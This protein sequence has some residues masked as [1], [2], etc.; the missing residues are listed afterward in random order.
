MLQVFEHRLERRYLDKFLIPLYKKEKDLQSIEKSLHKKCEVNAVSSSTRDKGRISP[1]SQEF[2]QISSP[3]LLSE[4]KGISNVN[5]ELVS[6]DSD[7]KSIIYEDV[8]TRIRVE[9]N[10]ASR[11]QEGDARNTE[12]FEEEEFSD[13][14]LL[15]SGTDFRMVDIFRY[16][17]PDRKEAFTCWNT[18]TNA[19]STNYGTRIDYLLCNEEFL[20]CI[21]DSL[22]L[23]DVMGSDH[24]PVAVLIK[25][26]LISSGKFPCIC[27]KF[28]PE[29]RGQQQKLSSYF[30]P[31]SSL[32]D[33]QTKTNKNISPV[34]K[35]GSLIVQS[36][37]ST[38]KRKSSN[39]KIKS[40]NKK[41]HI[42]KQMKLSSFF[43]SKVSN[44]KNQTVS[45]NVE[46]NRCE[47]QSPE[48]NLNEMENSQ[49]APSHVN[50]SDHISVELNEGSS[51]C[52]SNDLPKTA[53]SR[54]SCSESGLKS[55]SQA[56]K[57][58]WGF[59]MKGPEPPP[60]C[61]GHKE[62]AVLLTVKKKGPNI[63]RQFYA[64]ARGVGKEGDP[65]ARCNFFKWVGK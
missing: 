24:C 56:K 36:L 16:F 62:P 46:V 50:E 47:N 23:Q 34:V 7:E 22:I 14:H 11:K 1:Q 38:A 37:Q 4:K 64:C 57:S 5:Q 29:F 30:Q 2:S 32:P 59:L 33:S 44:Q 40:V 6:Y 17:Y 10:D 54:K 35:T 9:Q 43:S 39:T 61:P 65:N 28:F 63:N 26:E 52:S 27:T 45:P 60:L 20:P 41:L 18:F 58:G 31:K 48:Q 51:A 21:E 49:S 25:G 3:S 42:D 55:T 53:E 15:E 8:N 13:D 12:K 19:R